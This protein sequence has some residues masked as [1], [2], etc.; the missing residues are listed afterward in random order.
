VSA[1]RIISAVVFILIGCAVLG[2]GI[3]Q[4][5]NS[6]VARKEKKRED[7]SARP[8]VPGLFQGVNRLIFLLLILVALFVYFL[9]IKKQP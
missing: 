7:K 4:R 1:G 3:V 5:K 8:A 6:D 2:L 9:L